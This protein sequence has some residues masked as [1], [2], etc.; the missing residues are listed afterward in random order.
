V[1]G[2]VGVLYGVGVRVAVGVAVAVGDA[3]ADGVGDCVDPVPLVEV[4]VLVGV[5]ETSAHSLHI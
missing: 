3:V 4:G 5:A 2:V 1:G